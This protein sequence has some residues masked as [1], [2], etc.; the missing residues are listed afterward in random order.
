M[1]ARFFPVLHL[2]CLITKSL[3]HSKDM[4]RPKY[5][6]CISYEVNLKSRQRFYEQDYFSLLFSVLD[7]HTSTYTYLH[8]HVQS[9]DELS[10][11][12]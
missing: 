11:Y 10:M 12:H 4:H 5:C 7:A 3:T 2:R 8:T 1:F 6:S 9:N